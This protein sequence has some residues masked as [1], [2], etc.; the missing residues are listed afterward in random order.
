MKQY[1][2]VTS[3]LPK[4]IC[5]DTTGTSKVGLSAGSIVSRG[6]TSCKLVLG[7]W[8]GALLLS[9]LEWKEQDISN[10]TAKGVVA[11][12]VTES[13]V[14]LTYTAHRS[15]ITSVNLWKENPLFFT[16]ASSDGELRVYHLN[17]SK[18]IAVYHSESSILRA[19]WSLSHSLIYCLMEES[20][21]LN[22][23]SFSVNEDEENRLL[24]RPSGLIARNQSESLTNFW[25]N[26]YKGRQEEMA[27]AWSS[28]DIKVIHLQLQ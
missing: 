3:D 14:I 21:T 25:L 1:S 5:K 28:G 8:G 15:N 7:C 18:P 2:I 23:I 4:T 13:P 26:T 17:Q 6:M 9:S 16:S 12:E 20:V 22:S 19:S 27:L 11:V 24:A 10:T